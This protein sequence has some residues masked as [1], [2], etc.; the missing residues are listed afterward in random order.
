MQPSETLAQ[1]MRAHTV[2]MVCA[3]KASHSGTCLS[4]A[5]IVAVL[6][7]DI[8]KIAP[9][10]PTD[11]QRDRLILSKGHGAAIMAAIPKCKACLLPF[12]VPELALKGIAGNHGELLKRIGLT[13]EDVT[14]KIMEQF[15]GRTA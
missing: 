7:Q 5:D 4:A 12:S 6:Y 13:V 15:K 14:K 1:K 3:A 9:D 8:L 2:R 11:P 10:N